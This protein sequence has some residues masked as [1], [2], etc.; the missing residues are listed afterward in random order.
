MGNTQCFKQCF[1]RRNARIMPS[2]HDDR[3]RIYHAFETIRHDNAEAGRSR[4][5]TRLHPTDTQ[6]KA[7]HPRCAPLLPE[8]S[9]GNRQQERADAIEGDD[10]NGMGS[11]NEV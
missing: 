5:W 3:I 11:H 4:Q 1:W 8:D 7:R 9:A 2:R 10:S 6:I